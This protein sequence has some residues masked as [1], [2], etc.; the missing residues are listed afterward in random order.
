MLHIQTVVFATDDSPAADAARP[1]AEA[2]ARRHGATLHMLRVEQVPTSLRPEPPPPTL[3]ADG[4]AE[5]RRRATSVPDG[6]ADYAEAVAADV[7]V[8]GTHGR[9][10]VDRFLRGSV[11]EWLARRAACP[12]LVVPGEEDAPVPA[13]AGA[14]AGALR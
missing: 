1:A 12:V 3:V 11:A 10:G 2:L 4:V 7:V 8:V 9:V 13:E 6:I 14:L 5:A